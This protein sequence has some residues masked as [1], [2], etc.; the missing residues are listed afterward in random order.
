MEIRSGTREGFDAVAALGGNVE[1][2]RARWQQPSFDPT[3]HLWFADGAFGAL[4]APDEA[5]VRGDAGRVPVL[6]E[7]RV[8]LK[9]DARNPTGA[10]LL[11]ER[12]AMRVVK[13]HRYYVKKL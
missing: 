11:Y 1:L 7:R 2:L 12:V 9:V 4:Y 8:G 5:V 6:L 13:R 10:V 3:H